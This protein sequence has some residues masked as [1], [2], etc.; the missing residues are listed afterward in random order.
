MSD[1]Q[2]VEAKP[3]VSS[4]VRSL[5]Q[6]GMHGVHA[7]LVEK[8]IRGRR[9]VTMS[10]PIANYVRAETG[11]DVMVGGYWLKEVALTDIK[12]SLSDSVADFITAF[13]G[14]QFDDLLG[15]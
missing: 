7:L 15:E 3:T 14:G 5:N 6:L 9:R 4:V 11:I 1:T 13:D 8:G 10:C 12:H 2:Q